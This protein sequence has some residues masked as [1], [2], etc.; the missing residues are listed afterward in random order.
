MPTYVYVFLPINSQVSSYIKCL[1]CV[2]RVE[3][4]PSVLL[5]KLNIHMPINGAIWILYDT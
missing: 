5:K 4:V 3:K 1:A 2:G